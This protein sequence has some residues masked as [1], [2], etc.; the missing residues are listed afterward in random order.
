MAGM[1]LLWRDIRLYPAFQRVD[2]GKCQFAGYV[3]SNMY[4]CQIGER[5]LFDFVDP[6]R[7]APLRSADRV[8]GEQEADV[9]KIHMEQ[10]LLPAVVASS[11]AQVFNPPPSGGSCNNP[12]FEVK[13]QVKVK[14]RKDF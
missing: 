3:F 13:V 14:G 4:G 9:L 7:N 5:S 11:T 12:R 2:G 1:S 6:S 8:V 10:F